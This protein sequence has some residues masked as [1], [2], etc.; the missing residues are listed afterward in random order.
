MSKE[1]LIDA[2]LAKLDLLDGRETEVKNTIKEGYISAKM[3]LVPKNLFKPA[4]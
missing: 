1:E 2:L 3:C 4:R